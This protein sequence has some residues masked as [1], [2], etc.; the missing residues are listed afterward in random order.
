MAGVGPPMAG[1]G[2]VRDSKAD[3]PT[4]IYDYLLKKGKQDLARALLHSDLGVKVRPRTK[5]SPGS[6]EVNGMDDSG[7]LDSKDQLPLA[8]I[9]LEHLPETSFL[10]EWWSVF[11]DLW[12]ASKPK[13]GVAPGSAS[14]QYFNHSEVSSQS[15]FNNCS[16]S[17]QSNHDL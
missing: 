16:A 4:Y 2:D 13:P 6:R 12:H 15:T 8:N 5:T 11:W 10:Q 9:T 17:C 7:D 1:R 3:L 14:A